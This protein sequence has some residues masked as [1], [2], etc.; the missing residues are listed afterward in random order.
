MKKI[1][2]RLPYQIN[3]DRTIDYVYF[4]LRNSLLGISFFNG[5]FSII[6]ILL[7]FLKIKF[8]MSTFIFLFVLIFAS[9]WLSLYLGYWHTLLTSRQRFKLFSGRGALTEHSRIEI[10]EKY[11]KVSSIA[12]LLGSFNLIFLT[13]NNFILA[14]INTLWV[15]ANTYI[16]Y[17][18]HALKY[19]TLK[20][21]ISNPFWNT[22]MILAPMGVF[23]I[24]LIS[25]YRN[26]ILPY[27]ELR[28]TL[29]KRRFYKTE[30]LA[31]LMS[32]LSNKN[33]V[34]LVL[35]QNSETFEP[36]VMKPSEQ[37]LHTFVAGP[38][39]SGKSASFAKNIIFQHAESAV[40]YFKNYAKYIESV[41]QKLA[42][43]IMRKKLS[44]LSQTEQKNYRNQLYD[45][46]FEKGMGASF[47]NG[48]YLNE[49]SGELIEDT[50][51]I[52]ERIGFPKEMLWCVEP[53]DQ[54]TEGINIFDMDTGTA[55]GVVADLIRVF[56]EMGSD[57]GT[58]FFKDA[59]NAYARNITILMKS[60][61]NIKHVKIYEYLNGNSPTLSEFNDLLEIDGLILQLTDILR[62][63]RDAFNRRNQEQINSYLTLYN[64][65]LDLW[66][67]ARAKQDYDSDFIEIP[68]EEYLEN[69]K[70]EN[71]TKLILF[72][73]DM[74]EKEQYQE[75]YNLY[76]TNR[77]LIAE[78]NII[79]GCYHYFVDNIYNDRATGKRVLAHDVNVSGMK[80][81]IRKLASSPKVRRIFFTQSTKSLDVLLKMGGFILIDSSRGR[82]DDTISKMIGQITDTIV[83][84]AALRRSTKTKDPFF[85]MIGDEQ[86]WVITN[87]TEQFLNQ[88][89]KFNIG[90]FS[91]YQNIEQ[92][93][94]TIGRDN[95][96]ALLN[97]YRNL[98]AFQG[99]SK[100]TTEAIIERAGTRKKLK[101]MHNKS[102]DNLLA[103]HDSN[104]ESIR[105]E[106]EEKEVATSTDLFRMEQFQFAGI[107]VIDDEESELVK[108][109]PTPSF[110][111]DIFKD[112]GANYTPLLNIN[113]PESEDYENDKKIFKIWQEQT[114][115]MYLDRIEKTTISPD[116]FT[117]PELLII[118][119]FAY[120]NYGKITMK[121][122]V[123]ETIIARLRNTNRIY[124]EVVDED[125]EE[126]H[127]FVY[128]HAKLEP[129]DTFM[130]SKT[131]M[132]I[133]F[134][135]KQE[136]DYKTHVR[137]G[138]DI[139]N[140]K[141]TSIYE[142]E[143]TQ[144]PTNQSIAKDRSI[145]EDISQQSHPE[146][147]DALD[148]SK[149]IEN[150]YSEENYDK[151]LSITSNLKDEKQVK[152]IK[153]ALDK[154]SK[155]NFD[156]S[157]F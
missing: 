121:D 25:S 4:T 8:S 40:S 155:K 135:G 140:D 43:P 7:S 96:D 48:F 44:H 110:E 105:E 34:T 57:G 131:S 124:Y 88:S 35:G 84:Q 157:A 19:E 141:A 133:D 136:E 139:V 21:L 18:Q 58:T 73:K 33:D 52:L 49:P 101:R 65:E 137:R 156:P 95:V 126:A 87:K 37:R 26:E 125:T 23:G 22:I 50:K 148:E 143:N 102:K 81:T 150:H 64:K 145:N 153:K 112:G 31:H 6:V 78:F 5:L 144:K 100:R 154:S 42:S 12:A 61:A 111:L 85:A 77:D 98:F 27:Q 39:G 67:K 117:F 91:L 79:N 86:G 56:A 14:T 83:Q 129:G 106:I 41:D 32:D 62:V 53:D 55:A 130:K 134:L 71:E 2:N 109:T 82:L 75:L 138:M 89:R 38:I 10:I 16:A 90:V 151:H 97:S 147:D 92:I 15:Q 108:V 20:P 9:I 28:E 113:N 115:R 70:K 59:E 132:E 120:F 1:L 60:V 128:A 123:D 69:W 99:S 114:E 142:E 17:S 76:I 72:E 152:K 107:H 66:I 119:G 146:N 45:D 104:N 149:S 13:L 47:I 51:V 24:L 127:Y 116:W 93:D 11:I 3:E 29:F 118:E 68:F 94:A 36:V 122:D 30:E 46:W 103:G 54:Y 80:N 63:Y 74:A